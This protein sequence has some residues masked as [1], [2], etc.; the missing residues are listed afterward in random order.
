MP[1]FVKIIVAVVNGLPIVTL[2]TEGENETPQAAATEAAGEPVTV[3]PLFG[4]RETAKIEN[5]LFDL[6]AIT[7]H[8]FGGPENVFAGHDTAGNAV[9][10]IQR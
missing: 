4:D 6:Q 8:S 9:I 7:S 10:V 2:A 5:P 1:N 3:T